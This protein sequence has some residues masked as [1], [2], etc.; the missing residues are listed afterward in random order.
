[1]ATA[2]ATLSKWA[3]RALLFA[4]VGMLTAFALYLHVALGVNPRW[5]SVMGLTSVI[6]G[7]AVYKTRDRWQDWRYWVA[8]LVCLAFH[9]GLIVAIQV[10][11]ATFPL[12]ILGFL[13]AFES[14]GIFWIL[15]T[16]T[17]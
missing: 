5:V 13:G 3:G 16:V 4:V 17:D 2:G 15:L 9:F 10:Y 1:V 6:F 7:L 14:A 8:L 11:L 12:A